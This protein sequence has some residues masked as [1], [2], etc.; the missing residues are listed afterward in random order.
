VEVVRSA[1]HADLDHAAAEA[2]RSWRFDPLGDPS[3]VWVL[4]PVEFHLN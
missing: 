1:G 4:V 2:V 3:G